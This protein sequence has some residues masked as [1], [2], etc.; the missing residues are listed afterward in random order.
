[1]I[2]V[3]EAYLRRSNAVVQMSQ[4]LPHLKFPIGEVPKTSYMYGLADTGSGFNLGY[5]YYQQSV[6]ERH[7]N[8]VLKFAHLKDMEEMYPFNIIGVEGGKESEQGK[9]GVDVTAVITYKNTFVV[10]RKMVTVSLARGEGVVCNIIFSLPLPRQ[11]SL[12]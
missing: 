12:Q 11:L 10:N 4:Q 6:A 5:I 2:P 8:L 1:M 7:P 3:F 9:G